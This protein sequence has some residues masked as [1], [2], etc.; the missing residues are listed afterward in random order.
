MN[1]DETGQVVTELSS[2]RR[3]LPNNSGNGL[4]QMFE[5][6]FMHWYRRQMA[7]WQLLDRVRSGHGL[8][9]RSIADQ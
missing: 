3:S 5:R 1:T 2:T 6:L 8:A 4:K 9:H 7:C